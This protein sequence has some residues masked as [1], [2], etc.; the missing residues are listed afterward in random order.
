MLQVAC[1]RRKIPAA[2][3][4]APPNH[5][6]TNEIHTARNGSQLFEAPYRFWIYFLAILRV[7]SRAGTVRLIEYDLKID[8]VL[9][10]A[11][12]D[13][14]LFDHKPFRAVKRL[15]YGRAA[16]PFTQLLGMSL[17]IFPQMRR[18]LIGKPPVLQLN[19]R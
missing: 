1:P 6:L 14:A 2:P 15:T 7:C 18:P 16:S 3:S 11:D 13:G 17:E 8:E 4:L 10:G 9:P 5:A 12:L 19:K